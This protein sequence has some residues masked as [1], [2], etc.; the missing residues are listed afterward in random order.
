MYKAV[1]NP[2]II[3][4]ERYII[5]HVID[6]REAMSAMKA[7][8]QLTEE[9]VFV[10]ARNPELDKRAAE[11]IANEAEISGSLH[12]PQIPGLRDADPDAYRPYI[13]TDLMPR[14]PTV[15][16]RFRRPGDFL[17]AVQLGMSALVA[18]DYLHGVKILHNDI[19]PGN[20]LLT[21]DEAGLTD[22][23]NAQRF[24]EPLAARAVTLEYASPEQL[25]G[26]DLD[27]RSDTYAMGQVLLNFLSGK[28]PVTGND[29]TEIMVHRVMNVREPRDLLARTIPEPLKAVVERAT[30]EWPDDRYQSAGEMSEDLERWVRDNAPAPAAELIA[31]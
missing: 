16:R 31:A 26:E 3:I 8:D 2:E 29:A 5:N 13:V 6:D 9:E 28:V 17:L 7:F 18:V 10:K 30:Q 20:L 1:H 11:R 22:F 21:W 27:Q 12:H 25:R 15:E 24:G 14:D 23:D 4:P 19:K